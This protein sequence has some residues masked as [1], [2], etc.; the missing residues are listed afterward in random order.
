[1]AQTAGDVL[2]DESVDILH[3]RHNFPLLDSKPWLQERLGKAIR[4]R[5]QFLRYARDH[6][7]KLDK[8]STDLWRP[9]GTVEARGSMPL[10]SVSGST[11]APTIASNLRVTDTI[12]LEDAIRDDQSQSS[13]A[14]SMALD[15]D[16]AN[17]KLPHLR[18]I[19]KGASTFECTLCWTNLNMNK[20][21]SW[22]KHA[23]SDLRPYLC[24]FQN[25]DLKL[26]S[27]RH[28]WFEH[29]IEHRRTH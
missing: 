15:D 7:A 4:Q 22:R 29:E 1:M 12:S 6:R 10:L 3:V 20:E 24:T 2:F 11:L 13:Y 21:D 16:D 17:L 5:R 26:F 18:D 8:G 27:D 9:K 25:C 19:S 28:A 23:L 14:L